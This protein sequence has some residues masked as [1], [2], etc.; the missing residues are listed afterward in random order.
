M[1]NITKNFYVQRQ[2]IWRNMEHF[3]EVSYSFILIM[4]CLRG[5]FIVLSTTYPE[6]KAQT[7]LETTPLSNCI[8]CQ[9]PLRLL[10]QMS[11][12]IL[13]SILFCLSKYLPNKIL[14]KCPKSNQKNVYVPLKSKFSR[15]LKLKMMQ[16]QM[17]SKKHITNWP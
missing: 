15:F 10:M 7:W 1:N 6:K 5:L 2:R 16:M 11:S 3:F 9:N 4:N 12:D 14:L 17:R 8:K 13:V